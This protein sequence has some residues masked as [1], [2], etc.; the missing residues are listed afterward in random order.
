MSDRAASSRG[1]INGAGHALRSVAVATAVPYDDPMSKVL[2]LDA[3]TSTWGA[4]FGFTSGGTAVAAAILGAAS[5]VAWMHAVNPDIPD[6]PSEIEVV[7]EEAPPPPPT[8]TAA[9][10]VAKPIAPPPRPAEAPPPPP[11]APAQAAKVLTQE[12]KPDE[13]LDLTGNT[14]VQGNADSY[15]GG[16]TTANGTSNTAVNA[17][18]SPTG[19][20]GGTGP[21]QAKPA[22]PPGPDQSRTASLGGGGEWSCPFPAEADTAQ[23]DEAYVT[24]Q[25]DVKADGTPAVVRVLSDPG[26]GFGR[27]ARRCAMNK[28]YATALDHDGTAI[29]GTTKAFRVH[30]SR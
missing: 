1:G 10:D 4:W 21:V 29:A 26:N 22:P 11:P 16:F 7:R 28:R 19:V 23:V 17:M 3:K 18:P 30:F 5:I 14:I 24:L 6:K 12:A 13:P 9:P 8:A 20:P 2:G 27:E 25:V 15:A